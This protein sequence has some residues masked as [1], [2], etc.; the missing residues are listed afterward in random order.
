MKALPSSGGAQVACDWSRAQVQLQNDTSFLE[1][2][3][4]DC[5]HR[6][7]KLMSVPL[8]HCD[9]FTIVELSLGQ[10]IRWSDAVSACGERGMQVC[11]KEQVR[12]TARARCKTC[13][14][15]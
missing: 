6:P 4:G 14:I 1:E 10:S 5:G 7:E 8:D 2:Y 13:S 12:N 15:A 9:G 3:M 11:S